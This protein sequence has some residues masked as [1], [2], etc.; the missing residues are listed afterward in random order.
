MDF[1]T[2]KC[3]CYRTSQPIDSTVDEHYCYK[4]SLLQILKILASCRLSQ[5]DANAE[6]LHFFSA[7][8]LSSGIAKAT[9]VPIANNTRL[10]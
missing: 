5:L 2:N 3:D 4:T 10:H 9:V 6:R 8:P 1:T 7:F